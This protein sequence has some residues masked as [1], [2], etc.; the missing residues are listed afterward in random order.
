MRAAGRVEGK[1]GQRGGERLVVGDRERPGA[2]RQEPGETEQHS[3]LYGTAAALG[4][5]GL[6]PIYR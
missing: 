2:Q 1:E 3:L 5:L 4:A 6:S